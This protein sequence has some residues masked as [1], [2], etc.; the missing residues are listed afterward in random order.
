MREKCLVVSA[1]TLVRAGG[2]RAGAAGAL[3]GG[4]AA[5]DVREAGAEGGA[6]ASAAS[7]AVCQRRGLPYLGRTYR[8]LLVAEQEVPVRLAEGR[9]RMWRADAAQGREHLVR[10]YTAH[11][12]PWLEARVQRHAGRLQVEPGGVAVQELGY[13]WGSCGKGGR[14]YFHWR[15]ILLPPRIVEYV[16]VHLREPHHTPDFWRAV[17]RVLPDFAARKQWLAEHGATVGSL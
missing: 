12:R 9:F 3:R 17:E 16:V 14:L 1:S 11:A 5:V 15:S 6:E 7:A 2:V 10:W 13:H 8:L 4:E